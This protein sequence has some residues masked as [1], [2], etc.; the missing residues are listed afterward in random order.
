MTIS[1]RAPLRLADFAGDW[2]FLR[3]IAEP[4]RTETGRVAGLVRFRAGEGGLICDEQGEMRLAGVQP[5]Q[6]TRRTI[7]REAEGMIE[8]R[9]G[10]GRPFHAFDPAAVWAE[11]RH[12]CTPDLYRVVYD[13]GAFPD[14]RSIWRVT[15]PKKDYV[16]T[17]AHRR[18]AA[19]A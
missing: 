10:D 1:F 7:W 5:M 12:D 19:L 14:W 3:I 6:A 4:D 2:S 9:F 8:V 13:F 11:A 16:M 15:G 17:T 18:A